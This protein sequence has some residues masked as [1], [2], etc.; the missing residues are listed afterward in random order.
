MYEGGNDKKPT[1]KEQSTLF[2]GLWMIPVPPVFLRH[3]GVRGHDD[4]SLTERGTEGCV[5]DAKLVDE[6]AALFPTTVGLVCGGEGGVEELGAG[7]ERF[8][9]PANA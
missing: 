1:R 8:D 9:V 4:L 5:L 2:L 6:S 7:L 3:S